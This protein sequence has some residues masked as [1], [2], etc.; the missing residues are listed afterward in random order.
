M[1]TWK[2]I[3]LKNLTF[4]KVEPYT[5]EYLANNEN[6][7]EDVLLC[8]TNKNEVQ[9]INNYK[10]YDDVQ[11]LGKDFISYIEEFYNSGITL[12]L[13]KNTKLDD[14]INIKF[15]L[16][17]DNSTLVDY[18]IIIAEEG[19]EATII[20]DYTS[21]SSSNGFHNGLT[22]VYAKENSVINVIKLQR[23]NDKSQSFDSNLA[24]VEGHGQVNWVS[25]ELGSNIS[26]ANYT[27]YLDG[28]ASEGNLSSIYIGDGSRK[29]DLGYTMIHKG[30]R[31]ISNIESKGVLMD[32]AKKVF[33]G[34]LYFKQGSR[35]SKGSEEEYVILLDPKV[36]SHSI[37]GLFCE[38]DD[39]QGAHAASAGQLNKDKLFYLMSRGLSERQAKKMIIESSFRPIIDKIPLEDIRKKITDEI[40]RRI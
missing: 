15:L 19:S 26:G 25:I 2:R 32:E 40:E 11:G 5:K 1:I 23:L 6:L 3:G 24:F 4:P 36:Q 34:N 38:E 33:R 35:L 30:I 31:S 8:K 29:L 7:A 17:Y 14:P 12:R 10:N 13:S 18:N 9:K 28:E 21:D 16:D 20:I 27:T 39:V 22:K 37:P